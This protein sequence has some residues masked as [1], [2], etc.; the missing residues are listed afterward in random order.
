LTIWRDDDSVVAFATGFVYPTP[1]AALA[2]FV[3]GSVTGSTSYR[4]RVS[5]NVFG[6]NLGGLSLLV[7]LRSVPEPEAAA[8]LLGVAALA[9]GRRLRVL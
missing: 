7:Q 4:F 3:P 9:V 5:D 8:L 2:A 6:D 1:E